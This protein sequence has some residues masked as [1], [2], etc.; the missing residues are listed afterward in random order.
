MDRI[1]FLETQLAESTKLVEHDR[2]EHFNMRKSYEDRLYSLEGGKSELE[3]RLNHLL[4]D[5]ELKENE[6]A[7]LEA[8]L[9]NLA[10][11]FNDLRNENIQNVNSLNEI[12][13]HC[14]KTT[15]ELE[16]RKA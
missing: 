12:R 6:I 3:S 11:D 13:L 7:R 9:K 8:Q 2:S 10:G 15:N 16:N 4:Y 14:Q 1:R 5:V